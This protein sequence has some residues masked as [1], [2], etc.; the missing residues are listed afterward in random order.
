MMTKTV[1]VITTLAFVAF[2]SP[3]ADDVNASTKVIDAQ[4]KF[5][6]KPATVA[7]Q[8]VIEPT[9]SNADGHDKK[10]TSS[11]MTAASMEAAITDL[12][13]GKTA[14]GATPMG[15]SVKQIADILKKTMMPKVA[16]AH[17]VDQ[18]QLRTLIREVS[19]CGSTKTSSLRG[20]SSELVKYR[21]QSRYHKHCR[22][23][24]AVKYTSKVSCASAQ[25][26]KYQVK[27][28]KCKAFAA[29]SKQYGTT[30]TNRAIA[31]K[32]A[33]ESVE[34][35]IKRMSTSFCGNSRAFG[36]GGGLANGM[37]DKYLKAKDACQKAQQDYNNKVKECRRK[38]HMYAVR[39]GQC[40]QYQTRMDSASCKRAVI[41]KDACESYAECYY[42]KVKAY[43]V[44]ERKVRFEE[45]DRKAEWRGLKRMS[46]LITSFADG[47]VTNKEVDV[48]KKQSVNTKFLT[49][50]YP[51]VP[52]L[53]KCT[54]PTLYPATGA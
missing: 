4:V 13:L 7:A 9:L 20:A 36:K 43:R 23:D 31:S 11:D 16:Y 42:S 25:R 22:G 3:D 51:R 48:C 12:M 39:K 10:S 47:K 46:C 27:V 2:A 15:G 24:E 45:R 29:A 8:A 30:K 26:M 6:A 14:F 35:Y 33:S 44:V 54:V 32:A 49:I 40:D 50:K 52:P 1:L 17:K 37:L 28:L 5:L 38:A 34:S 19:K 21:A 53:A 41:A 18:Q